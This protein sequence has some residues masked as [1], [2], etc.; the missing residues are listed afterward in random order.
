M[1]LSE[2]NEASRDALENF[3]AFEQLLLSTFEHNN[4]TVQGALTDS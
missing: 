1:D 4:S 3:A 2:E